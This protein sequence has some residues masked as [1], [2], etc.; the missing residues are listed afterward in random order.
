MVVYRENLK[1]STKRLL[2]LISELSKVA[3][4]KINIQKPIRCLHTN[5][6][7]VEAKIKSTILFMIIPKKLNV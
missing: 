5:S 6:K 4:Y 2:E 7:D 3:R 1:E